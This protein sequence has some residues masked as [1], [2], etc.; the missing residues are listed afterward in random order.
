MECEK[1]IK[2]IFYGILILMTIYYIMIWEKLT[3]PMKVALGLIYALVI[4][5]RFCFKHNNDPKENLKKDE[6]RYYAGSFI[7][8]LILALATIDIIRIWDKMDFLGKLGF[9]M[10]DISVPM[11]ILFTYL[12]IRKRKKETA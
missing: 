10:V 11:M 5:N 9:V 3:I 2:Y 6:R 1:R 12:Q 8:I 4:I 7:I